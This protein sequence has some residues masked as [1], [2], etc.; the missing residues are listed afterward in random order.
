MNFRRITTSRKYIPEV[1]GIRFLAIAW[2]VLYHANGYL[3]VTMGRSLPFAHILEVGHL[4]VPI[5]FV[6]SGFI[7]GLPFVLAEDGKHSPINLKSFYLRRLTRLEPAYIIVC[8][9]CFLLWALGGRL[10]FGRYIS[11]LTYSHNIVYRSMSPMNPVL[12]SLEVEAQFYLLMPIFAL[13]FRFRG[14]RRFLWLFGIS[15]AFATVSY[16]LKINQVKTLTLL[17]YGQFFIS[18]LVLASVRPTRSRWVYDAVGLLCLF[19]IVTLSRDQVAY[20]F[21]FPL[22]MAVI[23]FS[24]LNGVVLK[25]CACYP[26]VSITGGMCYSIY[27]VHY[28]IMSIVG[29]FAVKAGN[30]SLAALLMLITVLVLSIIFFV[31]IERPTMNPNWPGD[32]KNYVRRL[33]SKQASL[34]STD[35]TKVEE[36]V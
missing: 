32:L 36:M 33:L 31:T 4:G 1:D 7:L 28:P 22:L 9:I 25:A 6:L 16:I 34:G 5:F 26:V 10:E 29:V 14:V 30:P 19:L 8:T 2:V 3:K 15:A 13:M 20:A 35:E 23:C 18:G 17:N 11:S 27:L 12:W 21:L 24:I